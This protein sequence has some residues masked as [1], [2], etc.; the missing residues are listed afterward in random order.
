ML[1]SQS[2]VSASSVQ[3][4][5]RKT[6]MTGEPNSFRVTI[7]ERTAGGKGGK[8]TV[9]ELA[10]PGGRKK[11]MAGLAPGGTDSEDGGA[12]EEEEEE[13]VVKVRDGLLLRQ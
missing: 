8:S 13:E 5:P 11:W 4:E 2:G 6:S 9:L 1:F 3:V 12:A 7:K 10:A